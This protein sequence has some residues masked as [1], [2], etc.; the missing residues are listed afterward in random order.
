MQWLAGGL[1]ESLAGEMGW[2]RQRK[3]WVGKNMGWNFLE[4]CTRLYGS[5]DMSTGASCIASTSPLVCT[6]IRTSAVPFQPQNHRFAALPVGADLPPFCPPHRKN[7]TQ[8]LPL[9]L[10]GR[11]REG[12]RVIAELSFQRNSRASDRKGRVWGREPVRAMAREGVFCSW[13]CWE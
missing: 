1:G 13:S 9:G 3:F 6:A 7:H 10:L 12:A 4:L 5:M 2:K 11:K 8:H